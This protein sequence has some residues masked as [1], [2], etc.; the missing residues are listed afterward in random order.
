MNVNQPEQPQLNESELAALEAAKGADIE[1]ADG[2]KLD[3]GAEQE[4]E[5]D[6]QALDAEHDKQ[7]EAEAE[8][9]EQQPEQPEAEQPET[10][11]SEDEDD[12]KAALKARIAELEYAQTE[13]TI[14]GMVGGKEQ[15]MA[16]TKWA[17]T[18]LPQA[19][20]DMFNAVMDSG[21]VAQMQ[22]AVRALEAIYKSQVGHEGV[23]LGGK[24]SDSEAY[25]YESDEDFYA[26]LQNPLYKEDSPAGEA[27]RQK[28]MLKMTRMT[29]QSTSDGWVHA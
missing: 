10:T 23:R 29:T 11:D 13:A 3:T 6:G 8:Q 1:L 9:E 16:M 19:E 21:N 2:T 26:D 14:F 28:V 25:S 12:E 20:V 4:A 24:A 15:Y 5:L 7:V 18:G 22:F 27:F 17:E